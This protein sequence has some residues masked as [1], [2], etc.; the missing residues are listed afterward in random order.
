MH[1][2]SHFELS[3]VKNNGLWKTSLKFDFKGSRVLRDQEFEKSREKLLSY[4]GGGK[5]GLDTH[6]VQSRTSSYGS[7]SPFR[8]KTPSNPLRSWCEQTYY[9]KIYHISGDYV[10]FCIL[11]NGFLILENISFYLYYLP[12][13]GNLVYRWTNKQMDG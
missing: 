13:E 6:F 5:I 10:K 4:I 2:H 11:I 12:F 9:N 3:R 1:I 7:L 8:G